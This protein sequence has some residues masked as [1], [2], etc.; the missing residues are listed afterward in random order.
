MDAKE[1]VLD[2][3]DA[4]NREDFTAARRFAAN[5]LS[6]VGVLGTLTGVDAYFQDMERI[7]L[8]FDVKKVFVEGDDVCLLYDVT[9]T[10]VS[11]YGCGWYQ[12]KD[13]KIVSLRVV[14]DPRPVLEAAAKRKKTS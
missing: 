9:M 5:D 10:D 12:L 4:I 7:R 8:K 6:F 11:V 2:F 14:F 1:L 3:V 13:G